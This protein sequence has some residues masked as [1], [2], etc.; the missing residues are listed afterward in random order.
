MGR[1]PDRTVDQL[2]TW[3]A[4]L[5]RAIHADDALLERAHDDPIWLHLVGLN[6]TELL[7]LQ[8]ELQT[9]RRALQEEWQ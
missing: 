2:E 4:Y 7:K 8:R 3:L 6:K 5:I 9:E 1:A